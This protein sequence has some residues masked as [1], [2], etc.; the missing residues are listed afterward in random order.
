VDPKEE[1]FTV[2]QEFRHFG[3]AEFINNGQPKAAEWSY[4]WPFFYPNWTRGLIAYPFTEEEAL[5][6]RSQQRSDHRWEKKMI[7]QAKIQGTYNKPK[8]PGSWIH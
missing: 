4:Y 8:M 6:K 3:R 2:L 5:L 7:K 1:A